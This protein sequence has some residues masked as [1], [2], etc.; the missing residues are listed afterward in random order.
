MEQNFP[1]AKK[2]KQK[3]VKAIAHGCE[4]GIQLVLPLDHGD[5]RRATKENYKIRATD[6][7]RKLERFDTVR[8]LRPVRID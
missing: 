7:L 4:I 6:G 1:I 5:F 8:V 2:S 3:P